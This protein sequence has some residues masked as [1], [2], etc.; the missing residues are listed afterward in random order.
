MLNPPPLESTRE[1]PKT[2][3]IAWPG[4][5]FAAMPPITGTFSA[6]CNVLHIALDFSDLC[7]VTSHNVTLGISPLGFG[8]FFVHFLA[9]AYR[10]Q[11]SALLLA[12]APQFIPETRL[13]RC[14]TDQMPRP[15][16]P[17]AI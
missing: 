3:Q 8:C 6:L 10:P 7:Q 11:H 13:G 5:R 12:F 16:G 9:T 14:A 4:Q 17:L 2:S 1:K 15:G